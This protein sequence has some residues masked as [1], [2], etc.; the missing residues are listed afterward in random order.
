[1]ADVKILINGFTTADNPSD[2]EE[3]RANIVLVRDGKQNIIVDPGLLASQKELV[4]KLKAE[5]LKIS[6]ID[7]VFITHSHMDHY[8]NIGMFPRAK[9]L[10]YFGLWDGLAVED[11]NNNFSKDIKIIETPGHNYDALTFLVKTKK[12]IIAV[13]GDVFWKEGGPKVDPYATD[14]KKLRESR[15]KVLKLA[16]HIIPGHGPMFKVK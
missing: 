8:R 6:D 9:A 11:R 3:T 10:D 14:M 4:D 2:D 13:C 5:K 7:I 1:M 15:K 16:D 12:G